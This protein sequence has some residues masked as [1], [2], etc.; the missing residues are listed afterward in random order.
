MGDPTAIGD[1]PEAMDNYDLVPSGLINLIKQ[2]FNTGV[3]LSGADIGEATSFFIGCALSL[4]PSDPEREMRLLQKKINAGADFALTQPL[5][6][7]ELASEFIAGYEERYGVLTLPILVGV[8]PL[9]NERHAAFLHNEVPGIDIPE[10]VRRR[11]AGAG[12]DS[13]REGVAIAVELLSELRQNVQGAY[14]MPPFGRYDLA[15]EILE[16]VRDTLPAD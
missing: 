5:Y 8:L 7:P 10:P 12:Q 2:G 9:F 14:I 11:I 16:A 15:A 6:R 1:Y 4:N 3:D 13:A